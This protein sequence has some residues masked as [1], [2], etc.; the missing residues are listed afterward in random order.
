MGW[1]FCKR[2]GLSGRPSE[3]DSLWAGLRWTLADESP[4]IAIGFELEN[5]SGGLWWTVYQRHGI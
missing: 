2:V 4:V 3:I 1:S 5:V